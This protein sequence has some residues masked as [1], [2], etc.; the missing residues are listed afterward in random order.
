MVTAMIMVV[1]IPVAIRV[2]TMAVFVPPPM[3][4]GP[5]VLTRFVQLL[6]RVYYLSAFPAV[7]FR[8]FVQPMI[9]SCDA[10]LACRFI[11]ANGRC[12]DEDESARQRCGREPRPYEKRFLH[13]NLHID[14]AL[15]R[16]I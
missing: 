3:C 8:R 16:V 11:G 7:V 14:F 2:P 10:P 13:L 12:A 6:T 4:V 1:I 9:G 15:L 5:A